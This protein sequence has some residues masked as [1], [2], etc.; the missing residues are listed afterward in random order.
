MFEM[1]PRPVPAGSSGAACRAD[2]EWP[3]HKEVNRI[4]IVDDYE[5]WRRFIRLEL[6]IVP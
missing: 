6:M 1:Q 4:L 5:P 3:L 2:G